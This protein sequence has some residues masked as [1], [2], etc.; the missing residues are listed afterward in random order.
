MFLLSYSAI[1]KVLIWETLT[2]PGVSR[3]VEAS[4]KAVFTQGFGF[5]LTPIRRAFYSES[6]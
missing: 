2:E 4:Y 1:L 3:V 6:H 5:D